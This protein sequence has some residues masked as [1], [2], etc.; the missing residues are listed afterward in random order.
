MEFDP[1]R[2]QSP[3]AKNLN[4]VLNTV[5]DALRL[6][7]AVVLLTEAMPPVNVQPGDGERAERGNAVARGSSNGKG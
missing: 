4:S 5:N 1:R 7:F 3:T 6:G 2:N